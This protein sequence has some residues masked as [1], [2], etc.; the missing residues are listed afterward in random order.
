MTTS[1]YQA[2]CSPCGETFANVKLFDQHRG[3]YSVDHSKTQPTRGECIDP[4]SLG[5]SQTDGIW[6]DV[7][8]S[9]GYQHAKAMG[10]AR[11]RA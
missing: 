10:E 11:R 4:V 8:A 7:M 9:K 6:M 1:L 5:M 3:H 2:K